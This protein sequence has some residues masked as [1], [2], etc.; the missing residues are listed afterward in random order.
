MRH[1][2]LVLGV[3]VGCGGGPTGEPLMGD[4]TL[5]YGSDRPDLVVG[6]AVLT[7]GQ[8]GMQ[9]LV[10]LGSDEVDCETDL[11]ELFLFD[12]PEGMFVYFAVEPMPMVHPMAIVNVMKSDGH[13]TL[14]NASTGMVVI[15]AV[16]DRVTGTV[17][18]MI[19]D[20]EGVGTIRVAG[21]FD[22]KKCF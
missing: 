10:Q 4:V 2:W 17:S 3:L 16:G 6:S 11:D 13:E 7:E 1:A 15:E 14:I 21:G 18:A 8:D 5:E 9:M 22:V 12:G 19:V 20:D